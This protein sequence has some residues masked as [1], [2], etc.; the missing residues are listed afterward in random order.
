[1]SRFENLVGLARKVEESVKERRLPVGAEGLSVVAGPGPGGVEAGG[2]VEGGAVEGGAVDGNSAEV[3]RYSNALS[4][5][6]S[7][8]FHVWF[9][10]NNRFN[11]FYEFE[12]F[13]RF[14]ICCNNAAFKY[15]TAVSAFVLMDNHVHLQ[16]YTNCLSSFMSSLLI[17]YNRW[18][19][20]KWDLKGRVFGCP[21]SSCKIYTRDILEK[22]FLYILTNPVRAGICADA[23]DYQWSSYHYMNKGFFNPSAKFL[24]INPLIQE[25][26]F[27]S[28]KVL[29]S[30]LEAY[31]EDPDAFLDE[32]E[33][34]EEKRE[35]GAGIQVASEDGG[36]GLELMPVKFNQMNVIKPTYSEVARHLLFLLRG[37]NLKELDKQEYVRVLKALR[38]QLN[39]SCRQIAS[40]THE[41]Y[42]YI[43]RILRDS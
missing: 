15:N 24:A 35:H 41:S 5:E 10:G 22:N 6:Q 29:D 21:F 16:V 2:A 7:G 19:N 18:Y 8:F 14:L 40:V 27:G 4:R 17:S 31:L 11:V 42:A 3:D 32:P 25:Y 34:E 13:S 1:M 33:Y 23:G 12:D 43:F 28:Q 39:A 36:A 38:K 20:K 26:L 30:R 9:R 37:R